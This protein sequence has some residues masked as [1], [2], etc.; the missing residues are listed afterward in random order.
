VAGVV[1]IE[2]SEE[3]S[4]SLARSFPGL[5]TCPSLAAALDL[6]DAVV[7]ATP[8]TTHH[9]LALEAIGAGKHLMVE[10]PL[11]TSVAE[12]R[13]VSEAAEEAGVTLMV[14]HTF[15]YHSAV[16]SLQDLVRSGELGELYY[17]DTMRSDPGRHEPGVNVLFDLAPHDISILNCVLGTRPVSVECWGSRHAHRRLE[18]IAYVRLYYDKPGCFA[19]VHVSWLDATRVRRVT[20]VGSRKM[21]VFDDLESEELESLRVEDQHFVDC[22]LSGMRPLTDGENGL[23][24]VEVLECAQRSMNEGRAVRM[25]EV[26]GEPSSR[27][28][29]VPRPLN[30]PPKAG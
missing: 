18:D 24:V 19:N 7:V 30:A 3:R 23:A 26:R 8:P 21:V 5:V 20:V 12:A 25:D 13:A 4:A 15:E 29:R 17:L 28:R 10:K 1:V 2:S 16:W 14:G 6:V 11:A 27:P 9:D 22:L